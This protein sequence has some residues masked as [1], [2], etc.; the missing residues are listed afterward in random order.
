MCIGHHRCTR[1]GRD[2]PAAAFRAKNIEVRDAP[3]HRRKRSPSRK[4][5]QQEQS[6]EVI[7]LKKVEEKLRKEKQ[8]L[9][10]Q[11]ADKTLEG[12]GVHE[13]EEGSDPKDALRK[14]L[15]ALRADLGVFEGMVGTTPALAGVIA[16][17][18]LD[19]A[20][21]HTQLVEGQPINQRVRNLELQIQRR[22]KTRDKLAGDMV[23]L[24][25]EQAR[26]GAE[27]DEKRRSYAAAL[28]DIEDSQAERADL[29]L[30]KAAEAGAPVANAA[31][32]PQAAGPAEI[33]YDTALAVLLGI[34][35]SSSFSDA[36]REGING[37][38]ATLARIHSASGVPVPT[39]AKEQA[40]LVGD[41]E[42]AGL[43]Q[44]LALAP[45]DV[46]AVV[47][48]TQDAPV[49]IPASVP[50]A[51]PD[52]A[53]QPARGSADGDIAMGSTEQAG[54]IFD[55]APPTAAQAMADIKRRRKQM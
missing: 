35:S 46:A 11:L 9:E 53:T 16:Q 4:G 14:K 21:L 51:Q 22:D 12:T 31:A 3:T 13:P 43:S 27:L 40:E 44:E 19:I 2:A 37:V 23:D 26:I 32:P 39:S 29:L 49:D 45:A 15:A 54:S 30:K 25:A 18:K 34:F 8:Q 55:K 33:T 10:Q 38:A 41:S 20:A 47:E 5:G 36:E 48:N 52:P 24:E 6:A 17:T 7:R 50:A 28:K 1:C 42:A